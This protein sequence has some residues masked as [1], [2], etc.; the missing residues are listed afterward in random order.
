MSRTLRRNKKH[1]ID[2]H[3]GTRE[4]N[5]RDDWWMR[6]RYPDLSFEQAYARAVHRYT[7]D[8]PKGRFGIPRWYRRMHGSK[9]VRVRENHAL[10]LHRREDTWESHAPENRYRSTGYAWW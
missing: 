1:L 7:G 8:R 3:V 4:A 10:Y 5:Q 6:Y 2:D 9:E